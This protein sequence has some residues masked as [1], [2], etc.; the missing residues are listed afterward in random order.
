VRA[1]CL[2]PALG[3][4]LCASPA[5][6][7]ELVRPFAGVQVA[8]ADSGEIVVTW[9]AKNGV[10]AAFGTPGGTF[11]APATIGASPYGSLLAID[12]AGDTVLV[13][14]AIHQYDCGKYGCTEDSLGVFAVTRP[15]GGVF[16]SPV[17]L[18]PAQ[19][20]RTAAPQ[21]VMNRAGD[22]LVLMTI[23]DTRVVAA[24]RGA[25][26][27]SSFTALAAL[28]F[29]GG[30]FATITMAGMDEA[31]NT[32]FASRNGEGHPATIT[33]R[34]DGSY[35]DYTVLDDAAILNTDLRVGVG[36]AGH[37]VAVWPGGGFLRWATRQPGGM[38]G[39]PVTSGVASDRN[40]PPQRIGVDVQGR[41]IMVSAPNPVFPAH[42]ERQ[43]RRGT[44]SAP[45]GDPVTVTAPDRDDGGGDRFAIGA[46]GNAVLAW[47]DTQRFANRIARAAI[48][49]DGGPF[50]A[51]VRVPTDSAAG[52]ST[53]LPSVAIDGLGRAVLGWTESNGTVQ[54]IFAAAMTPTAVTGP[55]VVAQGALTAAPSIPQGRASAPQG[56]V[57]RIRADG[58]V[59]PRLTCV[60][61][62]ASCRGTLRIDVRPKP[63][64]KRIR[65]GSHRFTFSRGRSAPVVV[66][67]T[68]AARRAAARRSLKGVITVT[69][70][71]Y[72]AENVA[73]TDVVG[74][75]VRRSRR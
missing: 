24:G 69:T 8:A 59:R 63:G 13:W 73:F 66:R 55:T 17:R 37:A 5:A 71:A 64:A 39:P 15:A 26:A 57:L 18:A 67:A 75:T 70:N 6:A 35:D 9:A 49:T 45:F 4:A 61:A 60:S 3:L 33:R 44:I 74:V 56:Q 43:V 16:G 1:A 36:P 7:A 20:S 68:R 10:Q 32:T 14:E 22:W 46:G 2:T 52:D 65:L 50:S 30:R 38:F 28:G 12:G 72:A 21:L 48:A 41:T 27:P 29:E 42:F 34:V 58:T 11:T 54:R 31:G 25:T 62:V 51:P 40:Y 23:G 53:E 47:F 19:P